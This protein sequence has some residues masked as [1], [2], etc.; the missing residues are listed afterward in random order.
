MMNAATPPGLVSSRDF[1]M[2]WLCIVKFCGLYVASGRE[3][4]PKGTLPIAASKV[5]RFDAGHDC[6]LRGHANEGAHAAAGFED[7]SPVEA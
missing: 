2:K 3:I 7:S 1:T 5:P 4:L 6:R